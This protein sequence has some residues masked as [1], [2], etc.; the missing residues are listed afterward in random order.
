MLDSAIK[1]KGVVITTPTSAKS[2]IL[3][4]LENLVTLSDDLQARKTPKGAQK[5]LPRRQRVA[6]EVQT[7]S[8]ANLLLRMKR[9]VLI[10]DELDW[11]CHRAPPIE[12]LPH[13][14]MVAN[15]AIASAHV[16]SDLGIHCTMWCL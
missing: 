12:H 9:S 6:L 10:M 5:A 16:E 3:K 2:S 14:T 11:V 15:R 4:F 7:A 8:W 1:Y 13:L